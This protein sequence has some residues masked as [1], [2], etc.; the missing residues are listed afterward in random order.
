MARCRCATIAGI[1]SRGE[2][3]IPV[4]F[5]AADFSALGID[6]DL[7]FHTLRV[8]DLDLVMVLPAFAVEVHVDDRSGHA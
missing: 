4:A 5:G 7:P 3:Q 2:E 1:D 6:I 8:D